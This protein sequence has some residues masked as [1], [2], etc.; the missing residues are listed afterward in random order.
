MKRMNAEITVRNLPFDGDT[1][2]LRNE[3]VLAFG[4]RYGADDVEVEIVENDP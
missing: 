1:E 4:L 2:D 3:L